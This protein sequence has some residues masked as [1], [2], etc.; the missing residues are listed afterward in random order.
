MKSE[1]DLAPTGVVQSS[2]KPAK[3]QNYVENPLAGKSKEELFTDVE[4]FCNQFSLSDHLDDF[5]RGALLAQSPER[6]LNRDDADLILTEEERTVLEREKTHRWSQTF[7]LYW[8]C[9]M[10]SVAAAVEG[11][12]E[13]V[14]NGAQ[15]LFL[16][17][18]GIAGPNIT[19]YS[20]A[21]QN[22]LTGV[23]V[24]APFLSA[25]L[26]G[27]WL[28]EPLNRYLVRIYVRDNTHNASL[29]YHRK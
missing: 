24:G 21:M 16:E 26:V 13:T 22:Y 19:R 29:T 3:P 27:S 25:G 4:Q 1:H 23:I 2:S 11:M 10:C 28:T 12:D 20:P 6:L 9:V 14:V 18:L 5:K 7:T 17:I 8:L 15:A